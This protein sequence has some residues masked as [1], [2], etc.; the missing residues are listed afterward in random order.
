MLFCLVVLA[1]CARNIPR[2]VSNVNHCKLRHHLDFF[3][4]ES[5]VIRQAVFAIAALVGL[6][7]S[8]TSAEDWMQ[9]RGPDGQGKSAQTGLPLHWSATENVVWKTPLPGPGTSSPIVVGDSIYLAC[10]TGY[11]L[12]PG[13]GEQAQLMRQ[14]VCLDRKSGN[15]AWTKES[16]PELPE[17]AYEGEGAYHGYTGEFVY[18]ARLDPGSGLIYAS[19]LLADG[20]I[21]YVSQHN[22]TY[23]VPSAPKFELL[24]H[25]IFADEDSRTNASP[26]VD[27]HR[28]LLRNDKHI[29]CIGAK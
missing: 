2:C 29:Y 11:G 27:D 20:K 26:V 1:R 28:L 25:N 18:E 12:D 22:G 16:K 9:F 15:I 23:V 10:Y 8:T 3:F 19:P 7:I 13:V 17:H 6:L 5:A 24:A 21:Y 4:R 14:L